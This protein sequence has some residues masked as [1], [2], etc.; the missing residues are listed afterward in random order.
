MGKKN[1]PKMVTV[2]VTKVFNEGRVLSVGDRIE[3]HPK[4]AKIMEQA[5]Y[6]I[7]ADPEAPYTHP[8]LRK[9][10]SSRKLILISLR[11]QKRKRLNQFPSQK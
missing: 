10:T 8:P 6:A 9:N 7:R 1:K 3:V 11:F 4:R 5:G 2:Q